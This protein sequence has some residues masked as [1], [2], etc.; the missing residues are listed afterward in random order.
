[1]LREQGKQT[2]AEITRGWARQHEDRN[3]V[4]RRPGGS[5]VV[6]LSPYQE[7]GVEETTKMISSERFLP[8]QKVCHQRLLFTGQ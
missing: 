7:I 4:E 6:G 8:L 3:K 5:L 2:A 1:M